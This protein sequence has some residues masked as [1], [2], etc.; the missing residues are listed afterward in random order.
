[1]VQASRGDTLED[2]ELDVRPLEQLVY[3]EQQ[4]LQPETLD[5]E[6]GGLRGDL[7]AEAPIGHEVP[8]RHRPEQLRQQPVIGETRHLVVAALPPSRWIGCG[9]ASPATS[10]RT[11]FTPSGM[12]CS[13]WSKNSSA[14]SGADSV[15][16]SVREAVAVGLER[17]EIAVEAVR[18][19][20]LVVSAQLDDLALVEDEHH[21]GGT[22][23]GE[24]M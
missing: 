1:M 6:P 10:S 23:R 12:P 7:V 4:V 24:A 11:R 22:D 16:R 2:E 13:T 3:L 17:E 21:V 5:R 18:G 19:H 8:V 15:D 14:S 9:G 20:E